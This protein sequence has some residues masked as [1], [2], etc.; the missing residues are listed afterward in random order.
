MGIFDLFGREPRISRNT[1][2]GNDELLIESSSPT[3]NPDGKAPFVPF[4][5]TSFHDVEKIIKG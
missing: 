5:P 3:Q 1:E 2:K 4:K